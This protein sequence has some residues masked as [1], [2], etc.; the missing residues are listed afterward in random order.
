VIDSD[1]VG[2]V[3]ILSREE[4]E[5]L[6]NVD[7]TSA[8]QGVIGAGQNSVTVGPGAR[9][10]AGTSGIQLLGGGLIDNAGSISGGIAGIE[11]V[12]SIKVINSGSISGGMFGIATGG[13]I[14]IVTRGKVEGGFAGLSAAENAQVWNDGKIQGGSFGLSTGGDLWLWNRGEI[15]GGDFGVA[16]G[17]D[18][19]VW[20]WGRIDGGD[21]GI[22]L[23]GDLNLRNWGQISGGNFGVTSGGAA[24]VW[25]WGKIQGGNFGM[26]VSGALD[27]HNW[28]RITGGDFGVTSGGDARVWNWGEIEG[29]F[30]GLSVSG[31]LELWN[32]G[33]IEGGQFGVSAPG[34]HTVLRNFGRITGGQFAFI[35]DSRAPV[36]TN[37]A[38]IDS[39][40]TG[41][42][43]AG[44]SPLLVNHGFVGGGRTA[45]ELG[46]GGD[47]V[48]RLSG[49]GFYRGDVVGSPGDG[50]TLRL[51]LVG[52]PLEVKQ[53]LLGRQGTL[54]GPLSIPV[55]G[56]FA[57][58]F[59][60]LQ[61][62][63]LVSFQDEFGGDFGGLGRSLDWRRI[64]KDGPESAYV[65]GFA[66]LLGDRDGLHD[67]LENA[68]GRS[69]SHSASDMAFANAWFWN[70]DL[71]HY[72]DVKR[73]KAW[74]D[75]QAGREAT[76]WGGFAKATGIFADQDR[77]SHRADG[78]YSVHGAFVGGDYTRDGRVTLGAFGGYTRSEADVDDFGSTL[79]SD[80]VHGGVY[81]GCMHGPVA[82]DGAAWYSRHDYDAK[83]RLD[84]P[85]FSQ[86]SQADFDADQL[87]TYLRA[88]YAWR[89]ALDERFEISP[90]LTLA[91]SRAWIDG[92]R[93]QSSVPALAL[94]LDD[95]KADSLRTGLGLRVSGRFDFG[96]VT[97]QPELRADWVHEYLDDGRSL[98]GGWATGAF[99]GFTTESEVDDRDSGVIGAGVT[100]HLPVCDC[101]QKVELYA[102][103][104]VQVG[105][106]DYRAHV[107]NFQVKYDF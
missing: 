1:T 64:A 15:G 7:I 57:R 102:G 88:S 72:L 20:N 89:P 25:N 28:G 75:A 54:G 46:G 19:Y 26:S 47:G 104:D 76:R 65:Q 61:I 96:K 13:S 48:L 73:D 36:V 38:T 23:S 14:N 5:L 56:I 99:D 93:E 35:T 3:N 17:G 33:R 22:S 98:R 86:R 85:G 52:V 94:D 74:A 40:G 8:L 55:F 71:A 24:N 53:S 69:T 95:Q 27:L 51:D 9:I 37:F 100:F 10:D 50:D 16:A 101:L 11:S 43:F 91:Y 106:E 44:G 18:G 29:G 39:P 4:L 90:R 103:W 21:F 67:A 97:L 92:W 32:W 107:A 34:E 70:Q 80:D 78:D 42:R 81:G 83:R 30:S 63:R 31:N 77:T 49:T 60:R 68:S 87:S 41:I 105:R 84:L 45:V 66:G 6:P 59:E 62:D 79:S 58:D 82:L 12:E 2:P